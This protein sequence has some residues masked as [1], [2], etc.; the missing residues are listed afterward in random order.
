[1]YV[2]VYVLNI[3]LCISI[4]YSSI[5]CHISIASGRTMKTR[6]TRAVW[7]DAGRATRS[8]QCCATSMFDSGSVQCTCVMGDASV[9]LYVR[10]TII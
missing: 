10:V 9:L 1:M 2:H 3:L 4:A 7:P 8:V 5:P 6:S